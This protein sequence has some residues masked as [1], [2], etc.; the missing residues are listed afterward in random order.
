V[1]GT[2]DSVA[3]RGV[4]KL[5]LQVPLLYCHLSG[6]QQRRRITGQPHHNIGDL[7][8]FDQ[9]IRRQCQR[10]L[11][12]D[13]FATGE[14]GP[15][16]VGIHT[17]LVAAAARRTGVLQHHVTARFSLTCRP[18][19]RNWARACD[20]RMPARRDQLGAVFAISMGPRVCPL[21][22]PPGW[23]IGHPV[24]G[25]LS[26]PASIVTS[27]RWPDHQGRRLAS[28]KSLDCP[29]FRDMWKAG[30]SASGCLRFAWPM[31]STD[32]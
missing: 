6:R 15:P 30:I 24:D 7:I 26:C 28:R 29:L 1:V 20:C 8:G 21:M 10:R 22:G 27:C 13:P 23:W 32:P 2:G 25:A 31:I 5:N 3:G 17:E 16:S 4:V 14:S 18:Q 12:L 19:I 9:R 11:N